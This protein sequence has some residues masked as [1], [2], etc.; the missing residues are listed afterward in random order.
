MD[1][2]GYFEAYLGNQWYTFDPRNNARRIGRILIGCGRDAAD[3][4]ITYTFG[5]ASL[6]SFKVW[7]DQVV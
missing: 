4:P 3:V 6:V 7:T 2:T 5:P 1:F